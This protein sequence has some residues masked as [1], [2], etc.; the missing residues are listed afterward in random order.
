MNKYIG[1]NVLD[2]ICTK[3]LFT[4]LPVDNYSQLCVALPHKIVIKYFHVSDRNAIK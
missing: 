4:F 2:F 1:N 3:F